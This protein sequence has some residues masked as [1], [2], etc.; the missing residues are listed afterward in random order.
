MLHDAV[1]IFKN[2]ARPAQGAGAHVFTGKP[3]NQFFDLIVVIQSWLPRVKMRAVIST[4]FHREPGMRLLVL[5]LLTMATTTGYAQAAVED[6]R[7]RQDTLQR[8]QQ[9]AGAAIGCCPRV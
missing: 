7:Q 3:I 2:T 5:V 1:D 9:K 6:A 8:D 4:T